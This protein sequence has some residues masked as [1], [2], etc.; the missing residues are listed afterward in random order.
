MRRSRV[1][2]P[3]TPPIPPSAEIQRRPHRAPLSF[4]GGAVPGRPGTSTPDGAAIAAQA[5]DPSVARRRAQEALQARHL[6]CIS[7]APIVWL[8]S[9]SCPAT[10]DGPAVQSAHIATVGGPGHTSIDRGRGGPD[11]NEAV[12]GSDAGVRDST[13][14]ARSRRDA[15]LEAVLPS[16]VVCARA[17]EHAPRRD[18]QTLG[19][20]A[21]NV[22]SGARGIEARLADSRVGPSPTSNG[23]GQSRRTPWRPL[24]TQGR[25]DRLQLVPS[26]SPGGGR[27]CRW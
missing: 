13:R 8:K 7:S 27:R 18:E 17:A 21:S 9:R 12:A 15:P 5:C 14:R 24:A 22:A 26:F 11:R 2:S 1:R 19:T 6:K 3:S 25:E 20:H 10:P 16:H 4:Q 23:P